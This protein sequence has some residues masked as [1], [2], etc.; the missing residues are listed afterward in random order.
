MPKLQIPPNAK[1]QPQD[2][3]T[4]GHETGSME[5]Q[6]LKARL[7]VGCLNLEVCQRNDVIE[8][9]SMYG[10]VTGVTHFP[11]GGYAFVQFESDEDAEDAVLNLNRYMFQGIRLD[12]KV[13]QKD[14]ATGNMTT[15]SNR[16]GTSKAGRGRGGASNQ[17]GMRKRAQYD[18]P[19]PSWGKQARM[20]GNNAENFDESEYY[21]DESEFGGGYNE[22][23][24][25]GY[26][27]DQTYKQDYV[28]PYAGDQTSTRFGK[29]AQNPKLTDKELSAENE[30]SNDDESK[31][32]ET[33]PEKKEALEKRREQKAELNK[34]RVELI[35]KKIFE[36]NVEDEEG[37]FLD[38][39]EIPDVIICGGCHLI[40][41]SAEFFVAHR[42]RQCDRK[43]VVK[44][45]DEP[46]TFSCFHCNETLKTSWELLSHLGRKHKI[47]LYK[48]NEPETIEYPPL[49]STE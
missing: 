49:Y 38:Q 18:Q 13:A 42:Q 2:P 39:N 31:E 4:V 44:H 25:E 28:D 46:Q 3:R 36:E 26:E 22:E 5:L 35:K 37:S 17:M 14:R 7:F 45:K 11:K 40:T 8:L 23:N 34:K 6:A 16:Q 20:G 32:D 43:L 24:D 33:D 47:C 9:F 1:Y 15:G 29:A 27:D 12:V 30:D 10:P 41:S 19:G 48:E 21:Q